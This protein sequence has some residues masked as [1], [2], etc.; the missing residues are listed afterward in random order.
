MIKVVVCTTFRDF[1]GTDNDRIQLMFLDSL[2]KQTYQN[3]CLVTTTFGEKKVKKVVDSKL[4]EKS[5]V[6]DMQIPPSYRFSLTDVVLNAVQ[7]SKTIGERCIVVWCTCDIQLEPSFLQVLVD[8]YTSGFSGILHPNVVFSS[9]NDLLTNHNSMINIQGGIDLLF[10]D[11]EV[12]VKAEKDIEMYRFYDWGFFEFFMAS[13]AMVYSSKRINIY[14]K[15]KIKKVLNDRNITEE[16]KAYFQRC[17]DQNAPIFKQYCIDKG[18]PS[19]LYRR[20]RLFD[21]HCQFKIISPTIDYC[22]MRFLCNIRLFPS[23]VK[24]AMRRVIKKCLCR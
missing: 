17:V 2:T 3:Y 6:I 21:I 12:L 13:I 24:I 14:C 9:Y 23:T 11:G 4:G 15:Q 10:F 16:T 19:K 7:I 20:M 5:I 18:L 1:K 22:K 8:N